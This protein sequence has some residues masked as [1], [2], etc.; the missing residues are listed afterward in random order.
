ME[1]KLLKNLL[2]R[3]QV[4]ALGQQRKAQDVKTRQQ[5]RIDDVIYT[6]N[7]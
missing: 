3:L 4:N 1:R 7:L 2:Q 5:N 6:D